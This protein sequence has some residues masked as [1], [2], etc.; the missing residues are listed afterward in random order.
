MYGR[1]EYL[2][3]GA[4]DEVLKSILRH[5]DGPLKLDHYHH[6]YPLH[7]EDAARAVCLLLNRRVRMVCTRAARTL[8]RTHR[9]QQLPACIIGVAMRT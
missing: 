4:V 1:V 5:G 7:V 2:A 6:R 8:V 9:V 3:E